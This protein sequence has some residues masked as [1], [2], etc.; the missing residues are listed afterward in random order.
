[1][2]EAFSRIFSET[3]DAD[4]VSEFSDLIQRDESQL[5][6]VLTAFSLKIA[7]DL[8][9][10]RPKY[11]AVMTSLC[12]TFSNKID[13]SS[14]VTEF[15]NTL[16]EEGHRMTKRARRLARVLCI[17]AISRA[18]LLRKQ[19]DLVFSLIEMFI[20]LSTQNT[21][22][23]VPIY[24][25]ICDI[26]GTNIHRGT[27][28]ILEKLT[29]LREDP[30]T[31]GDRLFFWTRMK[32]IYPKMDI[33]EWSAEPGSKEWLARFENVLDA[34][35]G[36]LPNVHPLWRLLDS[37]ALLVTL[38]ELWLE[39]GKHQH[40]ISVAVTSCLPELTVSQFVDLLKHTK[41]LET[42]L[43]VQHNETLRTEIQKKV[44]QIV[45]TGDENAFAVINA[46]LDLKK[47]QKFVALLLK[48]SCAGLS[49][50]QT[51]KLLEQVE[52]MTFKASYQLL[53]AQRYR[54]SLSDHSILV[55]LFK[56]V[57]SKVKHFDQ[58]ILISEFLEKTMLRKSGDQTWFE[59]FS[60]VAFP[61]NETP[62][63][64]TLLADTNQLVKGLNSISE[65]IHVQKVLE[66][67][68]DIPSF[69]KL[70]ETL[71]NSKLKHWHVISKH[72]TERSLPFLD[73]ESAS[74]LL[75]YPDLVATAVKM[76]TLA[77][78]VLP[79]FVEYVDSQHRGAWRPTSAPSDIPITA[80]E[81][82]SVI[83]E[84]LT[85][86]RQKSKDGIPE[87]IAISLF[88]DLDD[89]TAE[90]LIKKQIDG[91]VEDEQGMVGGAEAI[92][93]LIKAMPKVAPGVLKHLASASAVERQSAQW[94]L[95]Q[96]IVDCCECDDV[97]EEAVSQA[98]FA[99]LNHEY[100]ETA[101]G[102]KKAELATAWAWKLIQKLDREIPRE[103]FAGLVDKI[104]ATGSKRAASLITE[105]AKE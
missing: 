24:Q 99:S 77:A 1:M 4:P 62:S 86:C 47:E 91:I 15:Q 103:L 64:D 84:V 43:S 102:K 30:P 83:P 36:L 12:R 61:E 10:R 79:T 53:R 41:L 38:P 89:A 72:V 90:T 66:E 94:K 73:K 8:A 82:P 14:L 42:A 95:R 105:I 75:E 31:T 78:A 5:I 97:P 74:I 70:I 45:S 32:Q 71:N 44:S 23:T 92:S 35:A 54:A 18:G 63:I 80:D 2:E 49:D 69:V 21:W 27:D 25:A 55:S 100:Q 29:P 20:N 65:I 81:A 16:I 60:G 58:S 40:V 17:L 76:P 33:G 51:R 85:R 11:L 13:P 57:G 37:N 48:R 52:S 3:A 59:I 96:W 46:L 67:C 22:M 6:P 39:D 50:D 68:K 9:D 19:K 34:T 101:S 98:I 26:L 7:D 28:L 87:E 88:R 93:K 56:S 104:T